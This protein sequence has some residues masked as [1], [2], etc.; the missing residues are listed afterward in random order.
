MNLAY[1][2]LI[3]DKLNDLKTVPQVYCSMLKSFVTGEKIPA[4]PLLLVNNQLVTNFL[5]RA[6][7]FMTLLV[8][9][10]IPSIMIALF[11]VV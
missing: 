3:T 7:L 6:N 8:N 5:I 2:K 4:I 11:L 10:V 9:N 1:Q